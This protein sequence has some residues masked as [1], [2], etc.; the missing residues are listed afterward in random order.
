MCTCHQILFNNGFSLSIYLPSEYLVEGDTTNSAP[1]LQALLG[2]PV[3]MTPPFLQFSLSL[4][5]SCDFC[6]IMYVQINFQ[7]QFYNQ[8]PERVSLVLHR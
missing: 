7:L 3:T 4:S 6:V 5:S 2:T 1:I 8:V